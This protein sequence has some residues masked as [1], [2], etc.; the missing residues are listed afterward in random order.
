MSRPSRRLLATCAA[1]ALAGLVPVIAASAAVADNTWTL[2]APLPEK[3]DAPGFALAVSPTDSQLVLAGT[4]TGSI[5][6][7]RDGGQTW[8]SVRRDAGHAVLSIAFNP[9]KPGA[10]L[11]GTRGGGVVRSADAGQ[12]WT[13]QAGLEKSIGR[14]FGFAKTFTMIGT[15]QG[16]LTL[17]DSGLAPSAALSGIS[18]SALA[19]AALND[20]SK[21]LAGGDATRGTE[22]LP[23]F[24]SID[25]GQSWNEVKGVATSSNMVS[26]L[27]AY[28]GQM[29]PKADTRP[30]LLGTNTGVYS[31][32][33]NGGTWL[34]LTGG[35]ALPATDFNQVAFSAGHADRYYVA[36][37]GGASDRG[38]VWSTTDNGA[39][40]NPLRPPVASVTALTLSSDEQP[41]LYV[42]TFRAADHA[43]MLFSYR[44]T[45]GQP[46]PLAQP[47]PSPSTAA[48]PR[49]AA[50]TAAGGWLTGLL[51]GPEAPYLALGAAAVAVLVLAGFAYFR[52]GRSRRL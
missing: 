13:A 25:G 9:G 47:L 49:A 12:T 14:S 21:L 32:V 48:A 31:S 18:V 6:R 41:T 23:L 30:V 33:D 7:S 39:H 37:D 24:N 34:Q 20:P 22:P 29:P 52:R 38:G 28:G 51:A 5:Y 16:V 11:A 15:E 19:V 50:G 10:V 43:V 3:L 40:F 44:D 4:A 17:K 46:Q 45:G 35:G 27:A 26:A 42:A 36:S 1:L 2:L 8:A